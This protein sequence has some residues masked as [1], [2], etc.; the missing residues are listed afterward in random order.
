MLLHFNLEL[1]RNGYESWVNK[2]IKLRITNYIKWSIFFLLLFR[3]KMY[4]HM[5]V[6]LVTLTTGY[7]LMHFCHY[8]FIDGE[9][10][11]NL[12][13]GCMVWCPSLFSVTCWYQLRQKVNEDW[14]KSTTHT[15]KT[16]CF[17]RCQSC[18]F[19]ATWIHYHATI[20]LQTYRMRIGM[21]KVMPITEHTDNTYSMCLLGRFSWHR[22]KIHTSSTHAWDCFE[23]HY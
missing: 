13:L 2:R 1:T 8:R 6:W 22:L 12:N 21:Q 17:N 11:V 3:I 10:F 14:T 16:I 18:H 9:K 20:F 7:K 4:W 15:R 23:I 19:P 5:N